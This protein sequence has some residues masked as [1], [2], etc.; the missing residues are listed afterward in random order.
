MRNLLL[1]YLRESIDFN[2][3]FLF[4]FL[5]TFNA[6]AGWRRKKV[7]RTWKSKDEGKLVKMSSLSTQKMKDQKLV[8]K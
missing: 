8:N 1:K 7:D 6:L 4:A 5:Y 2:T 3:L